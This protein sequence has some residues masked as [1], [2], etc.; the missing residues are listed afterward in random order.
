MRVAACVAVAACGAALKA[1]P[2]SKVVEIL[3]SLKA[4]VVKEGEA[5]QASFEKFAHFCKTDSVDKQYEI[6]DGQNQAS[7]LS[8]TIEK[9]G[10]RA[11]ELTSKI[12]K[13][14]EAISV[15]EADLKSAGEVRKKEHDEYVRKSKESVEII[16]T[17]ER[18]IDILG[19][20]LKKGGSLAQIMAVPEVKEATTVL[21]SLVDA[22]ALS[23]SD[24]SKLSAFLQ[25]SKAKA[26]QGEDQV[27]LAQDDGG[28]DSGDSIMDVLQ[29]LLEKA[30]KQKSDSDKAEMT[31]RHEFDMV[32]QNLEGQLHNDRKSL[33]SAKKGLAEAQEV[34]AT[35]EGDLEVTTKEVAEDKQ[36]LAD[37]KADCE[38]KAAEWKTSLDER[39]HEVKALEEAVKVIREKTGGAQG[40]AYGLLQT[41]DNSHDYSAVLAQISSAGRKARDRQLG[42]LAVKVKAILSS[43]GD[44]FSKVKG[45]IEDMISRLEDQAASEASHKA[46]CDKETA[47]S[48]AKKDEKSSDVESLSAKISKAQS[49]IAKRKEEV[50]EL[51]KEL[52]DIAATNQE[53]TQLRAT[54]KATFEA[55]QKDYSEGLDAVRKAIEILK[56]YYGESLVQI[57]AVSGHRKSSDV[58]STVIHILQVAESDFA[59]LLTQA[60]ES[61][62]EAELK[63]KQLME[64]NKLDTLTKKGGVKYKTKEIAELV[65]AVAENKDSLDTTQDELDAVL[66]YMSRLKDQC[67]AKA[68]PYEEKKR[69]REEEIEGLKNA[70]AILDGEG[71]GF[72]AVRRHVVQA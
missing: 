41:K 35:A 16:D 71:I 48:E 18:A 45:L 37:A 2:I 42:A 55:A 67:V 9:S 17:L 52:A 3:Q 11:E 23:T 49:T 62:G 36:A 61:E 22:A 66:D 72:L 6:R 68:E 28:K 59:E 13:L 50:S 30:E 15:S 29:D 64:E 19:K 27:S 56:D 38:E 65:K 8:A 51:Q 44:P 53:M 5:E 10:A 60:R 32:K 20:V 63:Y 25:A 70:L 4:K 31:S 46:F 33:A 69:R 34:K 40:Q 1:N 39:D 21:S 43:S 26:D 7:A 54:E 24:R 14:A 58:A 12:S 57:Q 47:M